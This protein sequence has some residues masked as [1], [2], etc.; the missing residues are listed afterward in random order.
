MFEITYCYEFI[1]LFISVIYTILTLYHSF[2]EN[3][4]IK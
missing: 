2:Y 4:E 3:N 1:Y